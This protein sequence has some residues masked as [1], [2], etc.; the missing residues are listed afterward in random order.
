M[1]KM[2]NCTVL[3]IVLFAATAAAQSLDGN[4]YDPARDPDIDLFMSNWKESVPSHTHG[5]LIER[6]ILTRGDNMHPPRKGAVLEYVNRFVHATLPSRA[7][8]TPVTLDGKQEVLYILGGTGTITGAGKTFDLYK[9]IAVLVPARLE[10][11][12]HNTSDE[13]LTMYLVSEPIPA[14][15]RPNDALLVKDENAT[16]IAGTNAHWVGILKGLFGAGDGLGT[17]ESILTCGFPAM[18]IF[19]PH[20]H[21][22]GTEE[23][24]TT[25]DEPLYVFL[26]KQI[27][28]QPVGTA[29]M[30]P[31]DGNTPHANFNTG[32]HTIT[33]FYFARY[34]DH[35]VRP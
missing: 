33:M 23:V 18:S 32:N 7:I 29:Y 34:T 17:I 15:F 12:M 31:P 24:W 11:T 30:I 4:P 27:R 3:A 26:G 19:H 20:S 16:P 13:P 8:T 10:F 6:P 5:T 28:Y 21:S 35:Q 9:G 25:I 1:L 14:G 22:E 2:F